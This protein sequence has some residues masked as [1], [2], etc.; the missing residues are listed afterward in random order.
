MCS[1]SSAAPGDHLDFR[2]EE[3]LSGQTRLLY[4]N[5]NLAVGVTMLAATVLALLEWGAVRSPVVLGWWLYMTVVS[6]LSYALARRYPQASPLRSNTGKWRAAFAAGAGLAGAGWGAAGILFYQGSHLTNQVWLAFVLGGMMLGAAYL[7]AP[8]P[9]A[10]LAFLIPAGFAPA[11]RLAAGG[12]QTHLVMGLLAA[13]LTLAALITAG[14]IYR[15]VDSSLRLQFENRH[16]V[17]SLQAAK[18]EAEALNQA[19]DLRVRERT[20]ELHKS[21]EQLRAGIVQ[22]ERM[23]EELLRAR[24]LESLGVMASGIAHDFN[25]L[26]T[27]IQGKIELAQECLATG[28]PVE[29]IL[30]Q[31]SAACQRASLLSSQLLTFATGGPPVRRVVSV[32]RLVMD[33]IHL[34]RSGSAN[35]FAVDIAEDLRLAEVDSAQI[36][37]V[38]H[39]ILLNARQSMPAGGTIEVQAENILPE[40]HPDAIIPLVRISIRDYGPGIPADALPRIFD[41]Y[42]T[43]RAG[44]SGPSLAAAYAIVS[45]HGGH[46]SVESKPGYGTL[47]TVDLPASQ[48]APPLENPAGA[49]VETGT[50]RLL[51]MDDEEIVRDVLRRVLTGL[52]YQVQTAQEGAE[53]IAL[54]EQARAAG[55]DFDAVLL[56]LTVSGGLGGVETAAQLKE[57]DPSSK[58]IVSSGYSDSAVM[59]DFARY[60]FD[61]VIPKPWNVTELNEVFR[62][63]LVRDPDRKTR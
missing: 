9:E 43:T 62:R 20:A 29:S 1:A 38:L 49:Q 25:D 21:A 23:E 37:Q 27:V 2:R 6:V 53:A 7:L 15:I 63:V 45:R 10:S 54:Y 32:A 30:D 55:E 56:D 16:L 28:E 4:A 36:G 5:T 19:V 26:L 14:R 11:L 47:F 46:I 18:D 12:D 34:A 22:R 35:S 44:S 41:P 51:V 31:A 42:F 58:L 61:A 39:S 50:E 52:G 40:N 13:V 33:A 57:M 17:E 8:R 48:E 60:G 3:I 24:K 59:S